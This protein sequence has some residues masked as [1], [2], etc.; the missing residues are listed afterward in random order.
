MNEIFLKAAVQI[1]L[2]PLLSVTDIIERKILLRGPKERRRVELLV[3]VHYVPRR[4]LSLAFSQRPMFDANLLASQPIETACD[5]ITILECSPE[6]SARPQ[7][8]SAAQT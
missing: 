1:Q 5:P 7:K 8:R 3:T 2:I 4:G 6:Y